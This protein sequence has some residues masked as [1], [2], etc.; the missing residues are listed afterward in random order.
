MDVCVLNDLLDL[1]SSYGLK[2]LREWQCGDPM[3][4]SDMITVPLSL[5]ERAG[6]QKT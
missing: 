6:L 2:S 5:K 4:Y 1:L 3:S